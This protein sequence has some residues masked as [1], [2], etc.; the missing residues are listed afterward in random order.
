VENSPDDIFQNR[1]LLEKIAGALFPTLAFSSSSSSSSNKAPD[2]SAVPTEEDPQTVD[3]AKKVK[4]DGAS[5]ESPMV[6]SSSSGLKF[7]DFLATVALWLSP[8]PSSIQTKL[9]FLFDFLDNDRDEFISLKD[10][11]DI[12][13]MFQMKKCQIG[14]EVCDLASKRSGTL[15]YL[16]KV[17]SRRGIWAGIELHKANDS[18]SGH[19]QNDG[20]VNGVTYLKTE[21]GKVLFVQEKYIV[22]KSHFQLALSIL[23]HLNTSFNATKA[24]KK[25]SF[26]NDDTDKVDSTKQEQTS[27]RTTTHHD[28]HPADSSLSHISVF[29]AL[30]SSPMASRPLWWNAFFDVMQLDQNAYVTEEITRWFL[31]SDLKTDRVIEK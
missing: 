12:F 22:L 9:K 10:L 15:R 24:T 6:A 28:P 4:I 21:T 14:D 23:F 11:C 19:P 5:S 17:K 31:P 1:P 16:G 26:Q 25:K 20:S 3:T 29:D 7:Q 2:I 13:S 30:V 27:S 8:D 18:S